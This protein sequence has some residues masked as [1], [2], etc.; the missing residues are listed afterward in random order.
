MSYWPG[1]FH[2]S[3]DGLV[4]GFRSGRVAYWKPP[5]WCKKRW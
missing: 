5:T 1:R 2:H 4:D 3:G